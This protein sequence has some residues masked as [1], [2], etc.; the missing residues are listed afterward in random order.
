MKKNI[1]PT[2]LSLDDAAAMAQWD[3]F[4][5]SHAE[6]T[7]YH[8]SGWMKTIAATYGFKP[9]LYA[10]KDAADEVAAVLPFFIIKNIMNGKR[11][12]SLPFS[13]YGGQL[14]GEA[15]KNEDVFSGI[16]NKNP[17]LFKQVELRGGLPFSTSF[18]SNACYT[19]HVLDLQ[20]D[21]ETVYKNINK[22]TIQY[23]IRKA[24]KAGVTVTERRDAAGMEEFVRLNSLTRKK[25]GVPSQPRKWFDH[26]VEKIIV[27]GDGFILL[28]AL[29]SRIIGA[30]IFLICGNSLHYK[31]NAS[32]PSILH[33]VSPNHLITWTGIKWGIE[34]GFRRLDFGRTSSDNEGLMRYKEMWGTQ[35]IAIPYYYFPK[36]V[37][38]SSVNEKSLPYRIYTAGWRMLPDPVA[39]L[40][41][42]VVFRF[43]A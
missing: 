21:V 37:G 23:S 19:R 34:H 14:L 25:H 41:S 6:G 13:D 40:A 16:C 20:R 39:E 32:D 43:L 27:R 36:V 22:R 8:L 5:K 38:A 42:S 1:E 2:P 26:L 29:D 7:P 30:S 9:L 10:A 18:V 35:A 12:V 24:E 15:C 28:A 17:N 4:V 31:Y 3:S 11:S 33:T